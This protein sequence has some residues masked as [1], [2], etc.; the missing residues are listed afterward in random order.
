MNVRSGDGFPARSEFTG[1]SAVSVNSHEMRN[2]VIIF[3]G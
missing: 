1:N 2:I 3:L